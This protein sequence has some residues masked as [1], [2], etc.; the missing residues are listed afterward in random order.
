MHRFD[1]AHE[2]LWL[3]RIKNVYL[4]KIKVKV[5]RYE[6]SFKTSKLYWKRKPLSKHWCTFISLYSLKLSEEFWQYNTF[7]YWRNPL[8]P[9]DLADIEDV[10]ED[11]L[12]EAR[13]RD[14][15]GA[16]EVDM[17]SWQRSW[18]SGL[19]WDLRR[20]LYINLCIPKGKN[21][22]PCFMWFLPKPEKW[23]KIVLKVNARTH[24]GNSQ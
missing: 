24:Y 17:E 20:H 23:G 12:A 8:P 5:K 7:L 9:I 19:F 10:S 2:V 14:R 1:W 15:D 18:R 21:Y 22:F 16:G 13:L 6:F 3:D 4:L 11:N